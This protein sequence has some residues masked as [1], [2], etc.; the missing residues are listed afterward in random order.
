MDDFSAKPG[1]ANTYGLIGNAQ[2]EIQ[3]EK[4]M[5]SSMTPTIVFKNGVPFI[6]TGTPG[7]STI[8]TTILQQLL[9][10]MLYD[11]DIV[12]ASYQPRFHHQW[13]PDVI[14]MEPHFPKTVLTELKNRGFLI[15]TRLLGVTQ[16]I[17]IE[18]KLQGFSDHRY[19]SSLTKGY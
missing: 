12:D 19:E 17:I 11:M 9:N 3:P 10:I 1:S 14:M 7:G 15:K 18:D 4:R 2:N 6:V 16:T 13:Y 5:L 8:I